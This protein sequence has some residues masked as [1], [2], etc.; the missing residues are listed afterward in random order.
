MRNAL[1][2]AACAVVVATA[3]SIATPA[4][5][6]TMSSSMMMMMAM[7]N[8]ASVTV[9]ATGEVDYTPDVA[10]VTLGVNTEGAS[11]GAATADLNGRANAVIAALKSLGISA[12]DIQTKN[13]NLY[14]RQSTETVK[15]AFVA[16]ES[17]G[18][19]TTIDK[20]GAALDA[21]LRAGANQTY[22]LSFDTSQGD[23]LYKQALQRAVKQAHDLAA[24]AAA[25]AGVRLGNV[26]TINFGSS[27]AAPMAAQ[28][29][30]RMDAAPPQLAAGT[31]HMSASVSMTYDLQVPGGTS[32]P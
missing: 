14:Y 10:Y 31:G 30:M 12:G 18:V 6:D 2:L 27:I 25:A 11:A 13:Y 15:A 24:I 4:V 17:I 9:Q 16:S 1:R 32:H 20:A 5:A 3:G 21:G 23:A 29:V 26:R 8:M 19:K 22:G 28:G 7:H